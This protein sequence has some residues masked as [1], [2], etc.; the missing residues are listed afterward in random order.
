MIRW[1]RSWLFDLQLFGL[2]LCLPKGWR[3]IGPNQARKQQDERQA[4]LDQIA[5]LEH[6]VDGVQR[7]WS[8][9]VA[10]LNNEI[11]WLRKCLKRRD[12][13]IEMH[14]PQ[15]E[16]T[17]SVEALRVIE[18]ARAWA[19]E[20][21]ATTSMACNELIAAVREWEAKHE[22]QN[23]KSFTDILEEAPT[24]KPQVNGKDVG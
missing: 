4:I 19:F 2:W 10:L 21:L 18:S 7:N 6:K 20:E 22:H 15:L 11:E 3:L 14:K 12:D 23:P 13:E 24:S 1:A 9:T 8:E 5:T 16:H 17:N